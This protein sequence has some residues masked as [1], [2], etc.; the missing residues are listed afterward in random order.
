MGAP[1]KNYDWREE[2]RVRAWSLKQAGWKQKD[3]ARAVGVTEGAVSQWLKR[4]REQ[5]VAALKSHP[6]AGPRSRLT[7]E[8]R[9]HLRSL[10]TQGALAHGYPEA[11]WT[12]RRVA[13]LIQRVFGVRS[14]RAH[15]SRLLRA[16]EQQAL[17]RW[18][19]QKE[20]EIEGMMRRGEPLGAVA[21]ALASP[22]TA[23]RIAVLEAATSGRMSAHVGAPGSAAQ[24]WTLRR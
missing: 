16:L 5:G 3:I 24:Y 19:L 15:C 21:A 13:D 11:V 14:H 6:S 7:R 1:Q 9:E 2:R 18:K 20:A 23:E 8:Q 17:E 12:S 22:E 10:L 4:A